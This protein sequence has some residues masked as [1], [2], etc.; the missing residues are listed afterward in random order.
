VA[1]VAIILYDDDCGFCRWATERIVRW[2]RRGRL[3]ARPIQGDDGDR[4]LH[5]VSPEARLASWHLATPDGR[6]YSGGA[7]V[8]PLARLLPFGAVIAA[9]ASRFPRT[10]ER[11]YR[12]VARNRGR[13]GRAVGA[14]AC[15]VDPSRKR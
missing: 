1:N 2:D 3:V 5:W 4:L 13:L 14:V 7:A 12:L 6:L 10:T 15:A 8:A 11:L 9:L